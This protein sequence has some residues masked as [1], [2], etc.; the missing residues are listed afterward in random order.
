MQEVPIHDH[1]PLVLSTSSVLDWLNPDT[2]SE[3]AQDIA[4]EQSI[5]SDEFT[6]HPVSKLVGSVKNQGSELVEE[7]DDPLL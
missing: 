7:I 2:T 6:W 3:E 4:K 1:R 5:P